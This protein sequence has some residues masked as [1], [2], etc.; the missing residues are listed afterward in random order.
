MEGSKT[1]SISR[2]SLSLFREKEQ[3]L[4]LAQ[5]KILA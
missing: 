1:Q 3:G 2:V 5:H 4:G